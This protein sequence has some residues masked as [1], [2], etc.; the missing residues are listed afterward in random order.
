MRELLFNKKINVPVIARE[1]SDR[2]NLHQITRLL[3]LR[4]A[5]T[6]KDYKIASLLP[7]GRPHPARP[8]LPHSRTD[9]PVCSFNARTGKNACSTTKYVIFILFAAAVALFA[10][11]ASIETSAEPTTIT[12]GDKITYKVTITHDP[13]VE[14][15]WPGAG[16][17]LGQ[18]QII[19]YELSDP[20]VLDDG[21]EQ[22]TITYY[23]STYD[24]GD[25]II[26]PT[27]IA[28][29][30]K[31]DSTRFLR[32]EPIKITVK[33]LLS[34]EDWAKIKAITESDTT[35]AGME[36]QIAA[37]RA[38]Q[39]AKEELLRDVKSVYKLKRGWRFWAGI[40]IVILLLGGLV[41]GFILW[42]KHRG[43]AGAIFSLS[44]PPV[45]A[46]E[47]ALRELTALLAT[48]LIAQG[49]F[50]EYYSRLSE[51]VREYIERR[52]GIPALEMSSSETLNGLIASDFPLDDELLDMVKEIFEHCDLVKFAKLIPPDSWHAE[53]V[54]MAKQFVEQTRPKEEP[55]PGESEETG[56]TENE[57]E[58]IGPAIDELQEVE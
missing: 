32:T 25:W 49:N 39:M 35:Y 17:E 44:A 12:I 51:I 46:H 5:M 22:E 8:C 1:Q 27:G 41:V 14:I 36:K 20:V 4:L 43:I 28:Y 18:F 33:S 48:Q 2:N 47:A 30:D 26:P 23:I 54:E 29:V 10:Q 55:E 37:G 31:S 13:D 19:D 15:A 6:A 3:R 56:E 52:V 53:T 38:V 42:R 58:E 40:A 24:T 45:P 9:I 50:K 34:D 7:L 57:A 16:A 21:R 11:T